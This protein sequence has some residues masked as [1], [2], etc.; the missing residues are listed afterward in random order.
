VNWR[1]IAGEMSGENR[2]RYVPDATPAQ[3]DALT[4]E[5]ICEAL[6]GCDDLD[7]H[8]VDVYVASGEA[9]LLGVVETSNAALLARKIAERCRGVTVVFDQLRLVV[10]HA[11]QARARRPGAGGA[12]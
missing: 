7:A 11:E 3:N 6:R 12:E 4:R 1:L 2:D 5:L 10:A 8:D 9:T